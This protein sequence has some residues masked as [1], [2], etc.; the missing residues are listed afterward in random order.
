M[1]NYRLFLSFLLI[2]FTSMH[3][4]GQCPTG[5]M[6]VTISVVTDDYG[7][8]GYW[9]LVP[10]GN[11]CGTGTI[12]E[13]GNDMQIGCNGA[14]DQDATLGFG[15]DDNVTVVE[16]IGCLDEGFYDIKYVDDWGDG[17]FSFHVTLD[18]YDVYHFEGTGEG[19]TFTFEVAPPLDYDVAITAITNNPYNNPG[20]VIISGTI[21]NLSANTINSLDVNYTIDGGTEVSATLMGLNI[22][23]FTTYN[24]EHPIS[25]N[26]TENGSYEVG[27]YS[28]DMNGNADMNPANN[29]SV[30]ELVIGDPIPNIIAN[31]LTFTEEYEVI[32]SSADD[33]DNP[34]DL[35]F[36]PILS[37][38]Q[39][40]IVNKGT[41]STGGSTVTFWNA[42][43]PGQTSLWKQDGNAWHFMS[44]PTAIAFS[45]NTNFSTAPGVKDA[46]HS[47][48]TFTGPTLWSSD[49]DIY[50]EPSG[51][52]GSHL[53]ML[54]QSPYTMGIAADH[55][56]AFWAFCDW[57]GHIH[58]YD[59]KED[60]GPGNSDHSD[61]VCNKYEDFDIEM[62]NKDLPCHM[63]LD[64]NKQWLYLIDAGNGRII[65][66]DT[67]T[68]SVTGDWTPTNEP[69]AES[70]IISGCDWAEIVTEGIIE[71]VGIDVI[72]DYMLVSDHA[73]GEIIIY[74]ITTVPATELKRLQTGREG[75]M[76]IKI[77][78]DGMIWFV[79]QEE[80][81]LV[82]V[83]VS[84]AV[85][86]SDQ[87]FLNKIHIYPNPSQG[88]II[89]S[90]DA[91]NTNNTI[92]LSAIDQF[93]KTL[94]KE[95]NVMKGQ[96]KIDFT[97]FPAGTYTMQFESE[98]EVVS[99]KLV[100]IK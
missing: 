9:Q 36:H 17:G 25:W 50:A 15:Y 18:D 89:V 34:T 35:D 53:D 65:K 37:D 66:L 81:E 4:L 40:W 24:F 59:F 45:E 48:G 41:E 79:D 72:D 76:G 39:V 99:K 49:M 100:I 30:K 90:F 75:L 6:D 7:Y 20:E 52:N 73:T 3:L 54:H 96:M 5:Q 84:E 46:N 93:G 85:D 97:Y 13:G 29:F 69:L 87:S 88:E 31:Y 51:G 78:P 16:E 57:H 32:G 83:N 68:G 38:Y 80:D 22:T 28:G 19:N 74:D 98:K 70:N 71:P 56:N 42:G 11:T 1:N 23:P 14:G 61:G 60:H 10:L 27:L 94:Y 64:E 2:H 8:E 12:W 67:K 21:F 62:I 26:V 82:R 91:I 44:L 86:I 92:T 55:A 77:G 47:G 33:I 58:Y 43:Q 95:E 63:V